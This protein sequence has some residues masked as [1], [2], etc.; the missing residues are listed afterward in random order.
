MLGHPVMSDSLRFHGPQ[1]SGL[2]CTWN[3]P[4]KNTGMVCHF[5][6][7]GIFLNQGSN[8]GLPHCRQTLCLWATREDP[9][10]SPSVR[11]NSLWSHGLYPT[12]LLSPWGFSRQ[13]YWSGLP[14]PSP[15][16]LP[17]DWTWVSCIVGRHFTIWATRE[18]NPKERQCQRILKLP[19]SCTHLTH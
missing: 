6:L 19:H 15:E 9:K 11:S 4:G 18:V 5:Q 2:L 14:F 12:M 16:D 1:A 3:C 17:R 10:W 13:E 7:Q 8:P